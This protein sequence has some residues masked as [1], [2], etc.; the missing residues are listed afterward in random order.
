[1]NVTL[2]MPQFVSADA[3]ANG[4]SARLYQLE[5]RRGNDGVMQILIVLPEIISERRCR[6]ARRPFSFLCSLPDYFFFP[7][8]QTTLDSL[9][10]R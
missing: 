9:G 5:A 10:I 7:F 4:T 2:F 6:D 8:F 1:M 3:A